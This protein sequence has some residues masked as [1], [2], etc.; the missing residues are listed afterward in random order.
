[1]KHISSP[2]ENLLKPV[3]SVSGIVERNQSLP[4]V[5][6]ILIEQRDETVCFA[7][8]DLDIQIRTSAPVGVAGVTGC[9]TL[10]A[11][12]LSEILTVL[13]P[14]DAIDISIGEDGLAQL[15]AANGSFTMQTLPAQDFPVLKAQKWETTFALPAKT[16]RHLLTMTSFAMAP[17]D[18]RYFLM[19]VLF[20]IEGCKLRTVAT[21]THRL[22]YCD[23]EIDDL[24][25]PSRIEA[26]VPRKTVREL[27]RILPD[28][29]TPVVIGV[30]DTQIGFT[31]AGI[32][33]VSKLIEGKF[34]DYQRVMPT[35]ET[36]P[37]RVTIS[38]EDLLMTL[39]R[40]QVL[41]NERFHGIRWLFNSGSLLV[42]GNNAE[43]EEASQT[44]PVDWEWDELDI[45]FN[46]LYMLELLNNL[47]SN[48][49]IFH[50]APT[51][52]SVL[53]TTPDSSS[54]RYLI[55]PMRI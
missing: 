54:F 47:K 12:K 49:I 38:R 29:D 7:T 31:F 52:K 3:R 43:Q 11:Q 44:I 15:S 53:V 50:F 10:N 55:M 34:P 1:M 21:D 30:G 39:R 26:I 46:L 14:H 37:Q 35:P 20:V 22:A 32:E 33:F 8:T 4:I 19:G 40:V 45:G 42:Q 2:V 48:E 41:T 9:F 25:E 13:R 17:K 27:L 23:A 24:A 5:S 28:D 16:L 18:I 36:N 51:P 6:N